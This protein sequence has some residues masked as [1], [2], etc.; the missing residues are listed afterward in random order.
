MYR[1]FRQHGQDVVHYTEGHLAKI[2]KPGKILLQRVL[3]EIAKTP[4]KNPGGRPGPQLVLNDFRYHTDLNF[5]YTSITTHGERILDIL[6]GQHIDLKNKKVALAPATER[7]INWLS[8]PALADSQIVGFLDKNPGL[9]GKSIQ[10]HK[11][12]TYESAD[13]YDFVLITPPAQHKTEI[14]STVYRHRSEATSILVF[15]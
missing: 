15:D 9:S 7:S 2:S 3:D 12:S 11:V 6:R 10:G 14:I 4:S 5:E 1:L 13:D 8:H